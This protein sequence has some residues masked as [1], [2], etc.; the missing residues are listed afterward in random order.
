MDTNGARWSL[1][2]K[3]RCSARGRSGPRTDG[4][5]V[6]CR[7]RVR[8][9]AGREQHRQLVRGQAL[10]AAVDGGGP[11]GPTPPRKPLVAKPKTLAIVQ[12]HLQGRGFA[13]AEDE[14]RADEGVLMEGVP[15]ELRQSVDAAAE[16]GRGHGHQDLHLGR[17]LQHQS[18]FH[19]RR[20]RASTAAAS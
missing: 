6:G 11:P 9:V 1:P 16:I 15:A 8:G 17:E 19:K 2:G 20:A 18:A 13:I 5:P 10:G 4:T 14:D 12:K 7:T 3:S